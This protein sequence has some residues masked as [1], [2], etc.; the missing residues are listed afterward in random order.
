MRCFELGITHVQYVLYSRFALDR[1]SDCSAAAFAS[2]ENSEVQDSYLEAATSVTLSYLRDWTGSSL[3]HA[4][5]TQKLHN[6]SR[7]DGELA[8][9]RDQ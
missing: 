8:L 9:E 4:L 3:V 1:R 7:V 5:K 2:M 6:L